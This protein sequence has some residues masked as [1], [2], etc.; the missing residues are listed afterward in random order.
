MRALLLLSPLALG[1]AVANLLVG[2]PSQQPCSSEGANAPIVRERD[3]DDETDKTL[4]IV[5]RWTKADDS[6]DERGVS[7]SYRLWLKAGY[8][9]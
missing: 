8:S 9:V 4:F 2:N 7:T 5:E 1:A 6:V 3:L